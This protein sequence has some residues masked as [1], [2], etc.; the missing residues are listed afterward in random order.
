MLLDPQVPPARLDPQVLPDP[1]ALELLVPLDLRVRP[2][3]RDP[4]VQLEQVG[5]PVPA[6][7]LVQRDLRVRAVHQGLM[8]LTVYGVLPDLLV[9]QELPEPAVQPVRQVLPVPRVLLVPVAQAD[10]QDRP[11]R[12]A[13]TVWT[14]LTEPPGLPVQLGPLVQQA[15]RVPAA[16]RVLPVQLAK[17]VWTATLVLQGQPDPLDRPEPP[18]RREPREQ[19]V[20]PGQAGQAVLQVRLVLLARTE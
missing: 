14:V 3:P 17:M 2:V 4:L 11:A 15:Q 16:P 6:V 7:P 18:G 9:P 12:L 19:L 10:L 5:L 20:L 1:P 13:K 8:E